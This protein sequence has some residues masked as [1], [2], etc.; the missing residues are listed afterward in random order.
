MDDWKK[1]KID[2]IAKIDRFVDEFEVW[3]FDKIPYGKF[4][5]KIFETADG[6]YEGKTN[7][8]V[9]DKTDYFCA[10]VGFGKNVA[11]TLED[12]IRYFYSL[13]DE[14]EDLTENSF[15]YVDPNDF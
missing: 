14:V 11:E 10:G 3:E 7:L 4:K 1:I 9:K 15:D 5:V 2:Y 13:I 6:K 8:R 12:T